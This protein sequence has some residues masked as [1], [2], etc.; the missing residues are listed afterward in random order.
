MV[1]P[2][3]STALLKAANAWHDAHDGEWRLETPPLNNPAFVRNWLLR[4]NDLADRYNARHGLFRQLRP[5]PGPGR[6]GGHRALRQRRGPAPGPDRRGGHRQEAVAPAA[7]R[8]RRGRRARLDRLR[9]EPRQTDTCIGDWHYSRPPR[10][11]RPSKSARD[12]I[13]RLA[14][15]VS[16]NGCLDAGVQ[17][18]RGDGSIDDKEE[19]VLADMA[20]W[21]AINGEA[22][23]ATRPWRVF[24]EGP[25]RRAE[26]MQN[27]GDA[28]PFEPPTSASPPRPA[29]ST[30]CRWPGPRDRL[31]SRACGPAARRARRGA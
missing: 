13:Q 12:V 29:R 20:S 16:K 8:R 7:A 1:I 10:A 27:E 24:G 28:K 21:I 2:D 6:P 18:L 15:V 5:A 22:I 3:G 11:R 26:G 25:T 14:D 23:Y 30:P 31:R 19:K 9:D 4:Q 17:L